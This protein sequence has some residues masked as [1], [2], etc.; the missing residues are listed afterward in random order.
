MRYRDKEYYPLL[1]VKNSDFLIQSANPKR[2]LTVFTGGMNRLNSDI[3]FNQWFPLMLN[4]V[5]N[6]G[7]RRNLKSQKNL[8]PNIVKSYVS[9][10][11]FMGLSH[12]EIRK[13]SGNDFVTVTED[14]ANW[15]KTRTVKDS[16][17]IM[18]TNTFLEQLFF[19][20]ILLLV[21]WELAISYPVHHNLSFK[22]N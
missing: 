19:I 18:D 3:L 5:F 6:E 9:E 1:K 21:F 11:N 2:N 15:L 16:K 13:I 20:L 7:I 8:H 17:S 12:S 4:W 10:S 14:A 22:R